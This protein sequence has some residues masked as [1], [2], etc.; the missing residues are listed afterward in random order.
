MRWGHFLPLLAIAMLGACTTR[1]VAAPSGPALDEFV[2]VPSASPARIFPDMDH[3]NARHVAHAIATI[4]AQGDAGNVPIYVDEVELE[5]ACRASVLLAAAPPGEAGKAVLAGARDRSLERLRNDPT[6]SY[7]GDALL[8]VAVPF[9][10]RDGQT[11]Q[12]VDAGWVGVIVFM[13]CATPSGPLHA[14]PGG[15]LS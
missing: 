8:P 10:T 15:S 5:T 14:T 13:R 11:G 3:V 1:V 2:R 9:E 7:L 6:L 12:L 4:V